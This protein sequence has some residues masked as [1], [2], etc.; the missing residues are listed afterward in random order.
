VI[1]SV[2]LWN[3]AFD[4]PVD[5]QA[6]ALALIPSLLIA[7]LVS[8]LVRRLASRVLKIIVGDT[9]AHTS[10]LIS[11]PLRLLGAVAF[12][13]SLAIVLV[14]AFEIVELRPRTG[15]RLRTLVTWGFGSGL[16]I[17]LIG[18]LAYALIRAVTLLVARFEHEVNRGT[19]LDALERAKRG[20]T[21]GSMIR[22][23]ACV[24]IGSVAT[25]M[26]LNELGA[27][28]GPV[29]AGAGIVGLAVGFGAQTLVR[30]IISGFFLILE[31][32]V[33]VGDVAA[34]NGQGGYVEAINLRTI[35]LRDF[36]GTVHTF[37]N[38]GITTLAN[39]SKDFS[40]YV[41]DLA[42]PY[43]EDPDEVI[44]L[45]QE[46]GA[47]L[48]K[49][50]QFGPLILAPVEVVGVDNFTD[51]AVMLKLRIKTMP[52]KQWEV[53]RELRKRI[54]KALSAHGIEHPFPAPASV[55]SQLESRR[56]RAVDPEG[57]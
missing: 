31:D 55:A 3:R 22:N 40:F 53:G 8:R 4:S 43:H 5:W 15:I 34:I 9:L 25:L 18:G 2:S 42:I 11:G 41:I 26:I 46:V 39:R 38:G 35:V 56:H 54:L 21:L 45:M 1:A 57:Q 47:E 49:D 14:P 51:W 48:Q 33:R 20:R 27:N 7:W 37:P 23:V 44:A 19:S 28:I 10:P 32:Q 24:T 50:D 6:F 36:D 52:L 16:R 12:L 29:L 13:L 30:D 17:L